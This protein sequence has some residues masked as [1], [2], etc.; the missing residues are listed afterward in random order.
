MLEIIKTVFRDGAFFPK[1][2]VELPDETEVE[3]VVEKAAFK[4]NGIMKQIETG[5]K[6]K[7]IL[8]EFVARA[9]ARTISDDAPRRFSR[10]EL[11]ERR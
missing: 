6:R 10:E 3:I 8:A 7:K 1:T 11:H 9:G 5:E 4:E 2:P